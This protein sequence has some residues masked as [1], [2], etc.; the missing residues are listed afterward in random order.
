MLH[1]AERRMQAPG[2]LGLQLALPPSSSPERSQQ[3]QPPPVSYQ[4]SA[5]EYR[6]QSLAYAMTINPAE[7]NGSRAPPP[8]DVDNSTED[9]IHVVSK[10]CF[11]QE[12]PAE[13]TAEEEDTQQDE[14]VKEESKPVL[15]PPP[16]VDQPPRPP[17]AWILYRSERLRAIA[18]G[19]PIPGILAVLEAQSLVRALDVSEQRNYGSKESSSSPDPN[20]FQLFKDAEPTTLP[21]E[22]NEIAEDAVLD[23][24][25]KYRRA[26]LQ[27]DI[28]KVISMLW[29]REGKEVKAKY[30]AMA[31]AKKQEHQRK[32]PNYK[33]QP[34]RKEEKI[35]YQQQVKAEK[36]RVKKEVMAEKAH[37]R[38][39][40]K[41]A[42]QF[43]AAQ[44]KSIANA[45]KSPG[46]NNKRSRQRRQLPQSSHVLTIP[47]SAAH[48]HIQADGSIPSDLGPVTP[49]AEYRPL[50]DEPEQQVFIKQE[51]DEQSYFIRV[52]TEQQKDSTPFALQ[53]PG[54]EVQFT[55]PQQ[56]H[57][58]YHLHPDDYPLPSI[59]PGFIVQQDQV[60]PYTF[61]PI[62]FY[63]ETPGQPSQASQPII[64][65]PDV[66]SKNQP[67]LA[68]MSSAKYQQVGVSEAE[69]A[70]MWAMLDDDN[71]PAGQQQNI[72]VHS[73]LMPNTGQIDEANMEGY[74]KLP[75]EEFAFATR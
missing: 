58:T 46:E 12:V 30:E 25:S 39:L 16:R 20:R 27:A 69:L 15:P 64:P 66:S 4:Y 56:V 67:A 37:Q 45:I 13:T 2:S 57:P 54:A 41:A 34:L 14:T 52:P 1:Q 19:E 11:E 35:K 10:D 59:Q 3:L 26:L 29:K 38:K 7:V 63:Q 75:G 68:V 21:T 70:E 43:K 72:P 23:G 51:P 42:R 17:N 65:Y 73:G 33:Y 31:E 53:Y 9:S 48:V 71:V 36:E 50:P 28:S 44:D 47:L 8:Q 61:E 62:H 32:Y 6:P 24:G 60:I 74:S 40:A 18:A 22:K 49:L 55:Q 5:A